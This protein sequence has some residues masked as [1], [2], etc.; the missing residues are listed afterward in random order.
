MIRR[1]PRS[2][3]S[4]S[5][6]ASDVYKRQILCCIDCIIHLTKK[7][8]RIQNLKNQTVPLIAI[9]THQSFG[10]FKR[11]GFNRLKTE[12]FEM[13]FYNPKNVVALCH[14]W[15]RKIA[16]AFRYTW[17]LCHLN[18]LIYKYPFDFSLGPL[19]FVKHEDNSLRP[20]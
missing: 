14:F 17:F 19:V 7:I 2:T 6:A 9:L 13:L 3:Q 11:R 18:N 20:T 8:P 10:I 5:S 12:G 16:S 4:R 15:G 1:P